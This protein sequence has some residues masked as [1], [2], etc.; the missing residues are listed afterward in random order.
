MRGT[1]NVELGLG[2]PCAQMEAASSSSETQQIYLIQQ[3]RGGWLAG[4]S[5]WSLWGSSLK[6]QSPRR[7]KLW[8]ALCRSRV[9]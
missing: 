1:S 2:G 8:S 6:L 5:R 7:R 4:L 9:H 3:K